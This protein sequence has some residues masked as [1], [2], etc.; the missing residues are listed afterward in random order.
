M[1]AGCRRRKADEDQIAH[2]TR[3]LFTL[4]CPGLIAAQGRIPLRVTRM[5]THLSMSS[6]PDSNFGGSAWTWAWWAPLEGT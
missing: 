3:V 4:P 2:G 6:Y 5:L 1:M